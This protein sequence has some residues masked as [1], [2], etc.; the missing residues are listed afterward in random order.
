[1][2]E[3]NYIQGLLPGGQDQAFRQIGVVPILSGQNLLPVTEAQLRVPAAREAHLPYS[4]P[5]PRE[6]RLPYSVPLVREVL[7]LFS[8]VSQC[9]A[10]VQF[11]AVI[12]AAAIAVEPY[13]GAAA[14]EARLPYSVPL[15]REAHLLYSVPAVR[16]AHLLYSEVSPAKARAQL[17]AVVAVERVAVV[18]GVAVA[19]AL[20]HVGDFPLFQLA[21]NA[22]CEIGVHESLPVPGSAV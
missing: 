20:P 18:V 19:V 10:E 4:V 7:L 3:Q 2:Q 22:D 6:A 9:K 17:L 21:W 11:S 12:V 8:E 15:V 13:P 14:R 5:A 16:K 1:M